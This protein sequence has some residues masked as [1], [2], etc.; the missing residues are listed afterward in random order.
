MT[1]CYRYR[2]CLPTT[3]G[4]IFFLVFLAGI[5]LYAQPL[6]RNALFL[7][8]SYTSVN[9]LP[10]L[11]AALAHYAG[12][13]LYFGSYTPGGYTLGWR[14]T[15]HVADTASLNRIA[16]PGWDFVILQ[17][18][19]QTPAIP[20]LRDSCMIPASRIL[21]DS[22]KSANPCSRVLL[23]LT[24]GR[25]FGG[26]QCFVPN[27]CS[28]NFTDFNQMQDSLTRAY[29]M[30]ADSLS[31]WIAPVGESWRMV[32]NSTGMVL[33]D[34]DDSHPNLKGSYLAAC[35]FY[36]VI[37]GK[38]S[39]GNPFLAGLTPDTATLLQMAAD[40]VTFG[41][42]L[43]WNLNNDV[44][45][46]AF[47]AT[48]SSDTLFTQNQSTGAGNWLWDFGDGQTS[49][50]FSPMHVYQACGTYA[51]K[52]K[53]C[54]NCFCDSATRQEVISTVGI[55]NV[56]RPASL[57]QLVGPDD[58][59]F[60]W[61]RNFQGS[62]TL[63]LYSI[64]GENTGIFPVSYGQTHLPGKLRGIHFWMLTGPDSKN[65]TRGKIVR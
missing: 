26:I 31:A 65:L 41:Y 21:Y 44:P 56:S 51:V 50:W 22:I 46:A 1:F 39:H 10:A 47:S 62:G 38:P 58:S 63:F 52:L 61:F 64:T 7:G 6:R 24:W 36:D 13:S 28:Q 42:A 60:A 43:Q 55:R 40:S 27:Y 33:H 23:Y 17:E 9:N 34:V 48:L 30:D 57:I 25:R 12:D 8:N 59:G 32:I 45:K 49:T 16:Q 20:V 18:Q 37:F 35:V 5:N 3:S 53:A 29:T 11:V 15:A 4:L 54:N 14:P 19:S 2:H